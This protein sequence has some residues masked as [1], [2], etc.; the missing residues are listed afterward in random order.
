MASGTETPMSSRDQHRGVETVMRECAE[1]VGQFK[2]NAN[3]AGYKDITK[4]ALPEPD[5]C[6]EPAVKRPRLEDVSVAP[7]DTASMLDDPPVEVQ[8]VN[9][10]KSC[11]LRQVA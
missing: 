6:E 3:R 10:T 2:R 11:H 7:L 9:V 4:E 8:D 1:L 5:S